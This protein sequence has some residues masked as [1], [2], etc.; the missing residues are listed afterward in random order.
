MVQ[1]PVCVSGLPLPEVVPIGLCL[2]VTL[3]GRIL[4]CCLGVKWLEGWYGHLYIRMV[5]PLLYLYM[6][7]VVTAIILL[8]VFFSGYPLVTGGVST[9]SEEAILYANRKALVKAEKRPFY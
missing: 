7:F 3:P 6:V 5:K 1:V 9:N 2:E 4:G 8:V